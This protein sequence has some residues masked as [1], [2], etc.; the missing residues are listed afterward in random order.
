[1]RLHPMFCDVVFDATIDLRGDGADDHSPATFDT[2][3]DAYR[4]RSVFGLDVDDREAQRLGGD[5]G[6]CSDLLISKNL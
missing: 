2:L 4:Q 5:F 1:M 3:L 6:G